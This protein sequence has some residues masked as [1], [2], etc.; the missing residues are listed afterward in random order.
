MRWAMALASALA[1]I[2]AAELDPAELEAGSSRDCDRG[3]ASGR[4]AMTAITP[5]GV[6]VICALMAEPSLAAVSGGVVLGCGGELL[7][8]AVDEVALALRPGDAAAAFL[9]A[10]LP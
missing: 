6:T 10:V 9:S 2:E 5:S 3:C 4:Q 8:R 7:S 1:A